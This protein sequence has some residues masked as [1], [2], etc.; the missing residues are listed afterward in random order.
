[1]NLYSIIFAILQNYFSLLL[2]HASGNGDPTKAATAARTNGRGEQVQ[3]GGGSD[4][5]VN[6]AYWCKLDISWD[7][8][9]LGP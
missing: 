4:G 6:N 3:Q 8:E 9:E 2:N 1:M 7:V 5:D